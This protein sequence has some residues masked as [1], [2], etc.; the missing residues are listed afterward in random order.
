VFSEGQAVTRNKTVLLPKEIPGFN[1]SKFNCF[2][3]LRK[4]KPT[5][6]LSSE[7]I[8]ACFRKYMLLNRKCGVDAAFSAFITVHVANTST[9]RSPNDFAL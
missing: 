9:Q 1:F 7:V 5:F 3:Q 6:Q 2:N 8:K 4:E